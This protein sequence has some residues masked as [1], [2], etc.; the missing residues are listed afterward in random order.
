MYVIALK[1]KLNLLSHSKN[2][3]MTIFYNISLMLLSPVSS[4]GAYIRCCKAAVLTLVTFFSMSMQVMTPEVI[5]RSCFIR[6]NRTIKRL[7]QV[8]VVEMLAEM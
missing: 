6:T 8:N 7:L 5:F 3:K 2:K 1:K 4:K